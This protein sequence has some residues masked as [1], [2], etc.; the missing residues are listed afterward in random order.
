MANEKYAKAQMLSKREHDRVQALKDDYLRL[1]AMALADK[2]S[3]VFDEW[4]DKK[5]EQMYDLLDATSC[6]DWAVH[7]FY[8]NFGENLYQTG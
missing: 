8:G 1:E 7:V 2:Q 4:V 5:I 6:P 3:R